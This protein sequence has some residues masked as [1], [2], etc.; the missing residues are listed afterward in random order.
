MRVSSPEE[1]GK[2]GLQKC[3]LSP[4]SNSGGGGEAKKS[5]EKGE[6]GG[7][8]SQKLEN[9]CVI[10]PKPI[11]FRCKLRVRRAWVSLCNAGLFVAIAESH[12]KSGASARFKVKLSHSRLRKG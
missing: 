7:S 5:V 8:W 2:V 12:C 11:V 3:S 9:T 1:E 10:A 4:Q 6:N